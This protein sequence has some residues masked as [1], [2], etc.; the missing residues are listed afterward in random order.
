MHSRVATPDDLAQ[1]ISLLDDIFRRGKG[2]HDQSVLSDFPLLFDESHLHH[3]RVIEHD[4]Q[5]LSHAAVWPRQMIV[6]GNPIEVGIIVLVATV[7]HA[8]RQGLAGRLMKELQA[9]LA[10]SGCQV[11]L[12]W[13]GVPGFYEPLG[14]RV[15]EAPG[16]S[17]CQP[18]QAT[19]AGSAI[20]S[21]LTRVD[22]EPGRHRTAIVNLH[23][24]CSVHVN[25]TPAEWTQLLDLP[26]C[27]VHVGERDGQAV[28]YLVDGQATNKR[29]LCEYGGVSEDV[30]QLVRSLPASPEPRRLTIFPTHTGLRDLA[31]SAGW[32][33]SNLVSSKGF[34]VEM[35]LVLDRSLDGPGLL[36]RLFC[37]GLDQA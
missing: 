11:G 15:V 32:K 26:K 21:S 36:D 28:A 22:Y 8:R 37:W 16:W 9:E 3:C 31:Q 7:E 19:A 24:Q 6:D 17:A 35:Q 18:A 33:I 25:R 4:G 1:L 10:Q 29:G 20:D 23:R 30:W 12:L 14:W 2:V 34:G 5:L 13:T 27:L